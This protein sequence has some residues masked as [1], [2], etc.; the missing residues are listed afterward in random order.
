[1]NLF[2]DHHFKILNKTE[3]AQLLIDIRNRMSRLATPFEN[4]T[5]EKQKARKERARTD[6][7]YFFKEYLPHY[8]PGAFS[9]LHR[10]EVEYLECRG[11]PGAL[12]APRGF[13]KS[14]IFFGYIIHQG[15]NGLR[16]FINL[17]SGIKDLSE[18]QLECI[19]LE[20]E[21]NPRIKYDYGDLRDD[22]FWSK[23]M[24]ALKTDC[25][26]K[27]LGPSGRGFK[28]KNYRPDLV[29]IDDL[30]NDI[31]VRNR[32]FVKR[33]L[34]WLLQAVMPSIAG[35]GMDG[36]LLMIGTILGKK[37][38]LATILDGDEFKSWNRRRFQAI[39]N[40]QSLWPEVYPLEKL[41]K[42]K[43]NIGSRAFAKEYM[44]NP[45]D[46]EQG[47]REEWIRYMHI[48]E[49]QKLDLYIETATDPSHKAGEHNDYKAII[50]VGKERKLGIYV[51]MN[52]WIKHATT[53][54]MIKATYDIDE[55][56]KS[57]KYLLETI[58][59]QIYLEDIFELYAQ[60]HRLRRLPI[61]GIE[62]HSTDKLTRILDT[63]SPLLEMGKIYF[64]KGDS[65]QDLLI[66]QI[67]DLLD[68]GINDDGPDALEM[69]I[70]SLQERG[71]NKFEYKSVESR[72][73]KFEKGSW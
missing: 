71:N 16:H 48:S 29:A 21:E 66:E 54:S 55:R 50:T 58:G 15:V 53:Q 45:R 43:R 17:Y 1:M 59:G 61:K 22:N 70:R 10:T 23:D 46:E 20:I 52:A 14:T 65:D 44:N 34:D 56:Y 27:A 9:E 60:K 13:A 35:G 37:S 39:E 7:F 51:V 19:M 63:L 5:P 6:H 62:K 25:A 41:E 18:L 32:K 24:I 28:Y 26:I 72:R 68:E 38:V 36:T 11:I 31:N 67:L 30:E 49:V 3:R 40:G 73:L 2:A 12:A 47:I 4:D 42:I 8:F 69:V 33:Q 57:K 64:I